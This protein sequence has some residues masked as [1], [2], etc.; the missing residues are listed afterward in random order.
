MSPS[1]RGRGLKC[2][3]VWRWVCINQVALFTRAWIEITYRISFYS[4]IPGRPLYEGVDW[5]DS[6]VAHHYPDSMSPSLRGRGLKSPLSRFVLSA[7]GRPLH[8]GVDWNTWLNI[9]QTTLRVALFTR[10]WIEIRLLLVRVQVYWG[11]PLHEGVDWNNDC[12]SHFYFYHWSPS[13][14]GRGLKYHICMG[15]TFLAHVALFTRAW[16]EIHR[17]RKRPFG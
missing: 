6:R 13:S 5:N 15:V 2:H 8:E 1:L 17:T 4:T 3:I 10:A 12:T 7:I 16:I 9:W 14:R 11:R